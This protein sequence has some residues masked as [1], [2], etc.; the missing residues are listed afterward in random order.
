VRFTSTKIAATTKAIFTVLALLGQSPHAARADLIYF[1]KGGE[2]QAP[3]RVE[4]TQ[5]V[6]DLPEGKLEFLRDDIRK[7]VPGFWPAAEWNA[8]LDQARSQGSEARHTAI[9]WALE[10]GLTA[11]LVAELRALHRLAPMHAPTARMAGMLDRLDRECF[12]PDFAPFQRALGVETKIARGAHILLLHQH[13]DAEAEERIAT[14]ERVITGFYLLMAGQGIELTTPRQRFLTAWFANQKDYLAFLHSQ[15]A[16]AFATTRGYYHPTW[17]AVVAFDARSAEKQR[18]ARDGVASRR[19]ELRRFAAMIQNAPP[20]SRV[21]IKL[22]EEPARTVSRAEAK[23]V[24]G[25]IE[26]EIACETMMLDLEWRAVDLGTAA[27]EMIHQ[28]ASNSGLVSRHG[29]FPYWLHEGFAAQF[30]VV[31]GG[32]WAG[33]SR[34]HDLRLPDWRRLAEPPKLERLVRDSGFGRGYQRDLYAQAWALIY[35]LRT[36]HPQQFLTFIDLLRG[37]STAGSDQT[38][39][40]GENAFAAFQRAF[41]ADLEALERDWLKFMESVQTPLETHAPASETATKPGRAPAKVKN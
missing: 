12:D 24:L 41:G 27:H 11:E 6:L 3:A 19:E 26:R 29:A 10:N 34:A 25:R 40:R 7:L 35:F 4:G 17:N 18:T 37:P 39:L 31:R 28:L 36:Q 22:A 8:R 30:E 15:A 2:V 33:I 32:R 38:S 9:W 13:S 14:L 23:A 16:D 5:V 20:R 21:R 1:K